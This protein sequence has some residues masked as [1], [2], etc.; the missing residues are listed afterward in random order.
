MTVFSFVFMLGIF[1]V[2]AACTNSQKNA[3]KKEAYK[4]DFDSAMD[5]Y[6][7]NEYRFY[8]FMIKAVNTSENFYITNGVGENFFWRDEYA[9]KAAPL[10]LYGNGEKVTFKIYGSAKSACPD[11]QLHSKIVQLPYF[12]D[13]S[14]RE[15]CKG[16]EKF[17]LCQRWFDNRKID[18]NE[19][20]LTAIENYKNG[21]NDTDNNGNGE[22][23]AFAQ[24]F[25]KYGIVMAVVVIVGAAL[26]LAYRYF[27]INKNKIKI[28]GIE[29]WLI[30][31]LFAIFFSSS[32]VLA[33]SAI[34]G[35]PGGPSIG[36]Q[37]DWNA[38][39]SENTY[40]LRLSLYRYDGTTLTSYGSV[41]LANTPG[42]V[43]NSKTTLGVGKLDYTRLG[44]VVAFDNT[45][46]RANATDPIIKD[47]FILSDSGTR[48]NR[49]REK[50]IER[51]KLQETPEAIAASVNGFFKPSVP[52]KA[53]EIYDL[54]ITVEPAIMIHLLTVSNGARYGTVYELNK[55]YYDLLA[56]GN[57]LRQ[58]IKT[59]YGNL[60]FAKLN[61]ET[62][63]KHNFVGSTGSYLIQNIESS[64][65]NNGDDINKDPRSGYGIGVFWLAGELKTCSAVCA[66]L[67]GDALL[68]CAENYCQLNA[69]TEGVSKGKCIT[70]CGYKI[71]GLKCPTV[72]DEKAPK[73]TCQADTQSS[74]SSCSV[75]KSN[76]AGT[77]YSYMI[78]C[79]TA[80]KV[81]FPDLP[82]AIAPG[83]GFEYHVNVSGSKNCLIKFDHLRWKYDYAAAET[84]EERQGLM[85]VLTAFG[86]LTW[87]N[88]SYD[89]KNLTLKIE[90]DEIL[91]NKT[92]VI[93]ETLVVS[94]KYQFGSLDVV[95]K[96]NGNQGV[97]SYFNGK[98]VNSSV[99]SF[100]TTS[101]NGALYKLPPVCLSYKDSGTVLDANKGLCTG[102]GT[103]P[104]NKIY[105]NFDAKENSVNP[106]M[107]VVVDNNSS[108]LTTENSCSY[109]SKEVSCSLVP[110]TNPNANGYF[111]RG[112]PITF[113]LIIDGDRS[114][115]KDYGVDGASQSAL[116]KYNFVWP[117]PA[118]G[119][120]EFKVSGWITTDK[121]KI[122]C[123]YKL[124][125]TDDCP[126]CNC[127][128]VPIVKNG[129]KYTVSLSTA[130]HN[131]TS[132]Y[133][134]SF[135]KG[136]DVNNPELRKYYERS[137]VTFDAAAGVT[138][139]HG[140]VVENGRIHFGQNCIIKMPSSPNTCK[141][142]CLPKDFDCIR[143][144]C[145]AN[146]TDG[147][148]YTSASA[149]MSACSLGGTCRQKFACDETADII[150]YCNGNY[151]NEGYSSPASCINDC[152]CYSKNYF[153]RPIDIK[154]PFPDRK[155]GL[156]WFGLV[157][158]I[159]EDPD[160]K[161][162]T[163]SKGVNN[164]EYVIELKY[165][166][167]IAIRKDS[168]KYNS[169]SGNNAYLDYVRRRNYHKPEYKSKF[170]YD[171]DIQNGG[172]NEYFKVVDGKAN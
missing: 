120:S 35:V 128:F 15:E 161:T 160:D 153:Y 141:T 57:G 68:A 164:P 78:D 125:V 133:Y 87:S 138:S 122:T 17:E 110:I 13:Y 140:Y 88:L 95:A 76:I 20:F 6:E 155:E 54:Y 165:D 59:W 65:Q 46:N 16:L 18:S 5:S 64:K 158:Y 40:S 107:T 56:N 103:G 75:S 111:T 136:F 91:S 74:N 139:I 134:L 169:K 29:L 83:A 150:S 22:T 129:D 98:Q 130:G 170:I 38:Y 163:G 124:K 105:T 31:F 44:K 82:A 151:A 102:L 28:K 113:E 156:N 3:L 166:R 51:F 55:M 42:V 58:P 80:T 45:R 97:Y 37:P 127:A 85:N 116:N 114:L 145:A 143:D 147:G 2:Q 81:Q 4:I 106:T 168:S 39:H 71:E 152:G 52:V 63:D 30:F 84:A 7:A 70:D 123:P 167:T 117:N 121:K 24:F 172:F 60:I 23:N 27:V 126:G 8:Q 137:S 32:N 19:K 135:N 47:M 144:Y 112:A 86:N 41:D 118:S 49:I 108:G 73:T 14:L 93:K 72:I 131:A 162:S 90:V 115:V 25:K 62:N 157:D 43:I 100:S 9:S 67:S 50:V 79:N 146:P 101:N 171:R 132:K 53:N 92:N 159:T 154:N 148:R 104:Y 99:S 66:G 12:N 149:C 119:A 26:I 21:L 69:K 96:I 61:Q 11:E 77:D 33:G 36:I 34:I 1:N 94:D 109:I 10:G 142:T 89:S 48:E